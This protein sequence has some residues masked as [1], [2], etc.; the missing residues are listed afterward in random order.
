MSGR[1]NS[2]FWITFVSREGVGREFAL[3]V[4]ARRAPSGRPDV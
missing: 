4:V 2:G 1:T 3:T